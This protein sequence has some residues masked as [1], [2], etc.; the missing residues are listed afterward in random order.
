[1]VAQSTGHAQVSVLELTLK[2]GFLVNFFVEEGLM[3]AIW[4]L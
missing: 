3:D 1:M 2:T 4:R